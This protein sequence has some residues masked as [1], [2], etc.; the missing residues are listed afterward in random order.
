LTVYAFNGT[1]SK[2]SLAVDI[3]SLGKNAYQFGASGTPVDLTAAPNPFAV[4]LSIGNDAG[5][6]TAHAARIP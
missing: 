6:T 2:V 4:S 3:L 1:V 5:S